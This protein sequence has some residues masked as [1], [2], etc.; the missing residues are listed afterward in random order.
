MPSLSHSTRAGVRVNPAERKIDQDYRERLLAEARQLFPEQLPRTLTEL[1][2]AL[3][4]FEELA[5]AR[6][7]CARGLAQLRELRDSLSEIA[8]HTDIR[9][10]TQLPI[11]ARQMAALESEELKELGHTLITCLVEQQAEGA[12]EKFAQVQAI[13]EQR[14]TEQLDVQVQQMGGL[15]QVL[16]TVLTVLKGPQFDGVTVHGKVRDSLEILERET[17]IAPE[18]S[19]AR[20]AALASIQAVDALLRICDENINISGSVMPA[21]LRHLISVS[22]RELPEVP[23][24]PRTM[25]LVRLSDAEVLEQLLLNRVPQIRESITNSDFERISDLQEEG[26]AELARWRTLLTEEVSGWEDRRFLPASKAL[27]D[28]RP[29]T[30][31]LVLELLRREVE[32]RCS[33]DGALVVLAESFY[34][35]A[36]FKRSVTE[37]RFKRSRLELDLERTEALSDKLLVKQASK[38]ELV[39]LARIH[40]GQ[41]VFADI[42]EH[43]AKGVWRHQPKE[44]VLPILREVLERKIAEADERI[45]Q[46][47]EVRGRQFMTEK[48]LEA[49]VTEHGR[50]DMAGF[51]RVLGTLFES[52]V[53]AGDRS[54]QAAIEQQLQQSLL[55]QVTAPA[56][57]VPQPLPETADNRDEV[58]LVSTSVSTSDSGMANEAP[59]AST[60]HSGVLVAPEAVANTAASEE[61]DLEAFVR[62]MLTDPPLALPEEMVAEL[63]EQFKPV[64]LLDRLEFVHGALMRI[65]LPELSGEGVISDEYR[66]VV[67]HVLLDSAADICEMAAP[68]VEER[69]NILACN[70]EIVLGKV[71]PLSVEAIRDLKDRLH[72]F[73]LLSLGALSDSDFVDRIAA[74]IQGESAAERQSGINEG[75]EQDEVGSQSGATGE[76]LDPNSRKDRLRLIVSG[77]SGIEEL[78]GEE[79]EFIEKLANLIDTGWTFRG[80]THPVLKEYQVVQNAGLTEDTKTWK[81]LF[82]FLRD[83]AILEFSPKGDGIGLNSPREFQCS[84]GLRQFVQ[85]IR[86]LRNP[87]RS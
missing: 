30:D 28:A 6:Q 34:D 87:Q 50:V 71:Q 77:S 52:G 83:H 41:E 69:A 66:A 33:L 65:S 67:Q 9:E 36:A 84:V 32:Q 37:E 4:S 12:R 14:V 27:F 55:E 63:C 56:A 40:I 8:G 85:Q 2:E 74:F 42:S 61:E 44:S 1:R 19:A 47:R 68:E 26:S 5:D 24:A 35:R 70:I 64:V 13:V 3:K 82:K 7:E 18:S 10:S 78:R 48:V 53:F 72:S 45:E 46:I 62:A 81:K 43:L 21:R 22:G 31:P 57:S 54:F 73:E 49:H 38:N 76:S 51:R 75:T 60:S 39:R 58:P 15:S 86:D 29:A 17:A 59:E 25:A 79:P 20:G 80:G 11:V 23:E 16:G